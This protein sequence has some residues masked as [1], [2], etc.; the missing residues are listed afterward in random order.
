MKMSHT[1]SECLDF[2][3]YLGC[4]FSQEQSPAGSLYFSRVCRVSRYLYETS[5]RTVTGRRNIPKY[6]LT[7]PHVKAMSNSYPVFKAF[8]SAR[9]Y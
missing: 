2:S 6:V 1:E 7:H 9:R 5:L 4:S 3:I 8:E